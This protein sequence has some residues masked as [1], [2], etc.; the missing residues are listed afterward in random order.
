MRPLIEFYCPTCNTL[1][2]C[3]P[4]LC[5]KHGQPIQ[6]GALTGYVTGDDL[7]ERDKNREDEK[8]VYV[9][10]ECTGK[11]NG[12]LMIMRCYPEEGWRTYKW[13][14]DSPVQRTPGPGKIKPEL[15]EVIG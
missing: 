13:L 12:R 10:C 15:V 3:R 4:I 2:T 1:Q 6:V 7:H 8:F 11:C 14:V 5:N 9:L